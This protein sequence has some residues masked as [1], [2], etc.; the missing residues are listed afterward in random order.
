ML[1]TYLWHGGDTGGQAASQAP[2]TI[3]AWK[4]QALTH[5]FLHKPVRLDSQVSV[6]AEV[7][8]PAAAL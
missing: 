8:E 7:P 5:C 3:L 2:Q 6:R 1:R 4:V